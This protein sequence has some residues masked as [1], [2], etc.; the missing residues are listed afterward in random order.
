[1]GDY[2]PSSSLVTVMAVPEPGT[3]ALMLAGLAVTLGV[4]CVRKPQSPERRG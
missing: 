4:S 3:I 2:L 1:M